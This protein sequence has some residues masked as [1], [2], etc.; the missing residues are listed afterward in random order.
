[1]DRWSLVIHGLGPHHSGSDADVE[2]AA[3][4]FLASLKA[5][6][7]VELGAKL[8]MMSSEE[9]IVPATS[10]AAPALAVV[11]DACDD[12]REG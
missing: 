1:M 12:H 3:A 2:K 6:G 7:H 8:V 11:V 5:A 9:A 10:V 4:R